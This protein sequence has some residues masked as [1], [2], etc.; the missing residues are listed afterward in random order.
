MAELI[1]AR[2]HSL[3]I[4]MLMPELGV[5]AGGHCGDAS[6]HS[7]TMQ[8]TPT[9]YIQLVVKKNMSL[10]MFCPLA[11]MYRVAVRPY[12]RAVAQTGA[13]GSAQAT[14][15]ALGPRVGLLDMKV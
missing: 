13:V 6:S 5:A 1:S 10:D 14:C 15:C 9:F 7:S 2:L 3:P 12:L 11:A 8:K 4:F